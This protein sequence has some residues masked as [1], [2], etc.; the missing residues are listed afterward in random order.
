MRTTRD[1]RSLAATAL[2]VAVSLSACS[3]AF[4]QDHERERELMLTETFDLSGQSLLIDVADADVVVRN[5]TGDRVTFEVWLSAKNLPE[6]RERYER[7]NFRA[8]ASDGTISLRS[9]EDQSTWNNWDWRRWGGFDVIVQATVPENIDARIVSADGDISLQRLGGNIVVLS[10]D[11]DIT[12]DTLTGDVHLETEDGDVGV[13][14]VSG[15]RLVVRSEDGDISV[16]ELDSSSIEI[17]TTDGDIHGKRV[18]GRTIDVRTDDGDIVVDAIAGALS[19]QTHDGDIHVSIDRLGDTSLRT[20]DGDITIR[21]NDS[22]AA[23]LDLR[24]HDLSLRSEVRFDGRLDRRA[25]QG[26]L[27]GGGPTLEARTGEGTIV[28]RLQ[29]N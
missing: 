9:D 2:F 17:H 18:A 19:A 20:S 7:M 8:D 11:G 5:G 27:N 12:A 4:A 24:G 13:R 23:D 10:E 3:P 1:A 28:L 15:S 14:S 25:I 6:A 21:A 29:G 22:L 26:E 16:G